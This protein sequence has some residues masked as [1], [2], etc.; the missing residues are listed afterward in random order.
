[1]TNAELIAALRRCSYM[2]V[3]GADREDG[4]CKPCAYYAEDSADVTCIDRMMIDAADALETAEQRI[5]ELER[6]FEEV[7][8]AN[9]SL[10]CERNKLL[11]DVRELEAQ[12]PT[13]KQ[14][15][16]YCRKR[17]FAIV[18]EELFQRMKATYGRTQ[19]RGECE[20]KKPKTVKETEY[21]FYC[22]CPTCGGRLISNVDGEWCAGS[23]D[24]FC[25]MCGQKIDWS[26]YCGWSNKPYCGAR[27][28]GEHDAEI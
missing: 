11:N 23:F 22:D 26:E 3:A 13:E 27:M 14:V 20:A 25:R 7:C 1:M 15:V 16:D 10:A 6:N 8:N 2:T 12:E 18:E 9:G 17:C 4:Y 5:D 19:K 24:R 21:S 28:R